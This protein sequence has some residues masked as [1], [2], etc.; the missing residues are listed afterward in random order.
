MNCKSDCRMCK[1]KGLDSNHIQFHCPKV[2][3][4]AEKKKTQLPR[5]V[6]GSSK[7]SVKS[8]A[9]GSKK[10]GGS[11]VLAIT[12]DEDSFTEDDS[13]VS[14]Y[15]VF[16]D[17]CALDIYTPLASNLDADSSHVHTRVTDRLKVE[18]ADG[19]TLVSSGTGKF[20]NRRARPHC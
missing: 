9:S 14:D 1:S 17:T 3:N 7:R 5:P 13:E 4:A 20:A 15:Q 18:Q 10:S 2:S 8:G 19:T 12:Q 6:T 16:V 11:I